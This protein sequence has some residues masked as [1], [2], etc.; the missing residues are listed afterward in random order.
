MVLSLS[1]MQ[2]AVLFANAAMFVAQ[3]NEQCKMISHIASSKLGKGFAAL[4]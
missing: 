2:H 3:L 4:N 1:S